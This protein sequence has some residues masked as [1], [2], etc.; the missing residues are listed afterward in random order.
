MAHNRRK[1]VFNTLDLTKKW[2]PPIPTIQRTEKETI[3]VSDS[4]EKANESKGKEGNPVS[5][6]PTGGC[7]LGTRNKGLAN[8]VTTMNSIS[9]EGGH[10][11]S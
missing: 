9:K 7:V 6:I 5:V 3:T 8:L 11:Y 10:P 2:W 4:K 1:H